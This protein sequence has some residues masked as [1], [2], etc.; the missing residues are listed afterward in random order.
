VDFGGTKG[1]ISASIRPMNPKGVALYGARPGSKP[2]PRALVV[3]YILDVPFKGRDLWQA[4]EGGRWRGLTTIAERPFPITIY[5]SRG[6]NDLTAIMP[7]QLNKGPDSAA[8]LLPC[9][10]VG[11]LML[12]SQ[13][14]PSNRAA[15]NGYFNPRRIFVLQPVDWRGKPGPGQC[16]GVGVIVVPGQ[17]NW[18]MAFARKNMKGARIP[19]RGIPG[20]VSTTH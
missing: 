3:T 20:E 10:I 6:G 13:P 14:K 7:L 1:T 11:G 19:N 12:H 18:D 2:R 8:K 5:D 17:N 9:G 16:P 4:W 15:I